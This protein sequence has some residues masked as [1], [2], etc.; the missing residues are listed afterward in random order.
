MLALYSGLNKIQ[1]GSR[2][3]KRRKEKEKKN[4]FFFSNMNHIWTTWTLYRHLKVDIFENI[5]T[6][7]DMIGTI[8]TPY[9]KYID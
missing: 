9:G 8:G 3:R 7:R 2:G 5:S 4:T 6:F 1:Y